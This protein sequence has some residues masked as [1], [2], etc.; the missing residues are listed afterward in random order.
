MKLDRQRTDRTIVIGVIIM[1]YKKKRSLIETTNKINYQPVMSIIPSTDYAIWVAGRQCEE[2][3]AGGRL[4][5][6]GPFNVHRKRLHK[7]M[8]TITPIPR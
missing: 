2:A 5:N 3:R 8:N 1:K 7:I 4:Q 6:D